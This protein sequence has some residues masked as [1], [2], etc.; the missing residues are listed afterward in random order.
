M[1]LS[2][3]GIRQLKEVKP[4]SKA[5]LGLVSSAAGG[6]HQ[7]QDPAQLCLPRRGFIHSQ[8]ASCL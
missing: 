4:V 5:T 6:G 1:A 2:S 8:V 3:Q 7:G